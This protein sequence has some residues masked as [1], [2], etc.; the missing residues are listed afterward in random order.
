MQDRTPHT[1]PDDL[2]DAVRT[3]AASLT[4]PWTIDQ[5]AGAVGTEPDALRPYVDRLLEGGTI[6]DLGD[7][8]RHEGDG[9]APTLHGP[10][11]L[12]DSP[13]DDVTL[14]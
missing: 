2:M 9:P 14:D 8:P 6:V 5:L 10:P 13:E 7:D 1:A 3:A 11:P 12:D 4:A